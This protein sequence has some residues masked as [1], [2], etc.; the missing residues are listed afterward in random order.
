MASC[1]RDG[2]LVLSSSREPAIASPPP[3]TKTSRKGRY[4]TLSTEAE[5][6][7]R[8]VRGTCAG[9]LSG[10]RGTGCGVLVD[11]NLQCQCR[12]CRVR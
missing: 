11:A 5:C 1:A 12:L 10:L 6:V 8:D 3:L 9:E 7:I 4:P 2:M